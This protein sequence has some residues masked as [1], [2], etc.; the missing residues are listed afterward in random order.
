MIRY[1][2]LTLLAFL[3]TVGCAE[4]N[5]A[6]TL[7]FIE[8]MNVVVGD[9]VQVF[10]IGSDA[11]GDLLQFSLEE[12]PDG[13]L[14]QQE[15]NQA[16]FRWAPLITQAETGGKSYPIRIRVTDPTGAFASQNVTVTAYFEGGVPKFLTPSGFVINLAVENNVAFLVEVKD[17]DDVT[18]TLSMLEAMEGAL[19][20]QVSGK[21]ASFYWKPT[22]SQVKESSF[23]SILVTAN[24]GIHPVVQYPISIVLVN[25]NSDSCPGTPPSIQHVALGDQHGPSPYMVTATATDAESG[26][27]SMI[28]YWK[29]QEA[30]TYLEV[31]MQEVDNGVYSAAIQSTPIPGSQAS[32]FLYKLVASDNDD[33]TSSACDHE[34]SIPK[35]ADLAFV[36]YGPDDPDGCKE[37][38][39]EPNETAYTASPLPE[40]IHA[41]LRNCGGDDWFAVDV[42]D[43]RSLVATLNAEPEHGELSLGITTEF[44]GPLKEAPFGATQEI[45]YGPVTQL[46]PLRIRVQA[47]EEVSMTYSLQLKLAEGGC[48]PD[49][50]EPNDGLLEAKSVGNGTF[51]NLLICPGDQDWFAFDLQAGEHLK[52]DLL[53]DQASGDL[54]LILFESDGLSA[55]SSA[56]TITSNEVLEFDSYLPTTVYAVV[57]GFGANSNDYSL[58]ADLTDQAEGCSDDILSPNQSLLTGKV[59]T[60]GLWS[61]LMLCP[62]TSD[63]LTYTLNGGE[64]VVATVTP[65]ISGTL[66]ALSILNGNG[67]TLPGPMGTTSNEVAA[68]AVAGSAGPIY[69]RVQS[70]SDTALPYSLDLQ[71]KDPGT[72]CNSDRLEPNDNLAT[73]KEVEGEITTHLTLCQ[74]DDDW[75]FT[76]VNL[77]DSIEVRAKFDDHLASLNIS[78]VAINGTVLETKSAVGSEAY[79]SYFAEEAGAYYI[80]I[81]GNTG[82]PLSY[83]LITVT[84]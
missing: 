58:K 32:V 53:F 73:A 62:N 71:V 11:D 64:T 47:E 22:D 33:V 23:W 1:S 57:L 34:V 65:G 40:G 38:A 49:I 10:L 67:E 55:I 5:R 48:E 24:D 76:E 7:S 81:F 14:L 46:T 63:Y 56:I 60:E 26:I 84:Y 77:Y 43:G 68:E 6:P 21:V 37:D 42:P 4:E 45:H 51:E 30:S 27:D 13:A 12:A 66:P 9:E 8:D 44:G 28:L 18:V 61:G 69:V 31:P 16:L 82:V 83:D 25:G 17:D 80:R 29:S 75:L 19:F 72:S 59:I 79:L 2:P 50:L 3:F 35:A 39:Y 54:D 74:N 70:L 36:A 20:Q 78:L 41:A 52:L 15:G